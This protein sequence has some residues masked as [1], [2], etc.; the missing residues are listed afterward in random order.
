[1]YQLIF[2]A[3]MLAT[4]M[5]A[6]RAHAS[7]LDEAP[8][9]VACKTALGETAATP[10]SPATLRISFTAGVI[11]NLARLGFAPDAVELALRK[12]PLEFAA[13][14]H[15][16]DSSKAILS[17]KISEPELA[18]FRLVLSR[19]A[20][21]AYLVYELEQITNIAPAEAARLEVPIQ[22]GDA[23]FILPIRPYLAMKRGG[24]TIDQLVRAYA[25]PISEPMF[26]RRF[27]GQWF[28][29][30]SGD[31]SLKIVREFDP[32]SPLPFVTYVDQAQGQLV[33]RFRF[34][35]LKIEA[36]A[37]AGRI[38]RVSGE[39]KEFF[40]EQRG[41]SLDEIELALAGCEGLIT[42]EGPA[43]PGQDDQR[44]S[45]IA[46]LPKGRFLKFGLRADRGGTF[47]LLTAR[48]VAKG[49]YKDYL[50]SL[51]P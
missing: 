1:M 15:K 13:L 31:A 51:R 5:F 16:A 27:G 32:G 9:A 50:R 44:V 11:Q 37:L 14:R 22:A 12:S 46:D 7:K 39:A 41:I 33:R 49:P 18:I 17:V 36:G 3:T 23:A 35:N 6:T 19:Q 8:P 42:E 29:G 38:V 21:D 20:E 10:A 45:F 28:L 25:N 4:P 2:V 43:T 48:L 34:I 24:F 40:Q 26:N 47:T 30:D